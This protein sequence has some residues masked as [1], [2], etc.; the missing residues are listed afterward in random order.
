MPCC[1]LCLL[2]LLCR[3]DLG[4]IMTRAPSMWHPSDPLPPGEGE[5]SSSPAAAS[6]PLGGLPPSLS[7]SDS[8][9]E[10]WL[11]SGGESG[12]D[13]EGGAAAA[14]AP[15]RGAMVCEGGFMTDGAGVPTGTPLS[16]PPL[17][18]MISADPVL[19]D[20]KL[21]AEAWDCDGLNQAR[22][23]G[24]A[25]GLGAGRGSSGGPVGQGQG[26]RQARCL[27]LPA[28]IASCW[29]AQVF[30]CLN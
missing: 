5:P 30:A 10:G 19:K 1:L 17:I 4:S 20:T 14:G 18:D 6:A 24:A 21:I 9:P 27:G 7:G 3:F 28:E 15:A 22:P 13:A 2:C 12:S 26:R 29:E 23:G 16:D 11:A 25:R 8:D